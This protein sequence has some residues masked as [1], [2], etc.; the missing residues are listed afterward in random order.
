MF[1][2]ILI[3]VGILWIIFGFFNFIQ[4]IQMKKIYKELEPSGK[5][6]FGRD[7]AM[8]RTKLISFAAVDQKG[9]VLDA[10]NLKTSRLVTLS[11]AYP[12]PDIVG[13]NL[14][15]LQPTDL[16]ISKNIESSISN[17]IKNYTKYK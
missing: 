11:K 6:Y 16:N 10:R 3:V 7:A 9:N 1:W 8:F 17:L 5:V 2:N 13:K 14:N 15:T 12:F 4:T